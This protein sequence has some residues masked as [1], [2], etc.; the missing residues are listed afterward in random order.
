MPCRRQLTMIQPEL[1]HL[2]CCRWG[3]FLLHQ[4]GDNCVY[5]A[6]K[7]RLKVAC[8]FQLLKQKYKDIKDIK[9]L[10]SAIRI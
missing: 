7:L 6:E 3:E 2:T 4:S 8:V 9:Q 1:L 10:Q 5:F